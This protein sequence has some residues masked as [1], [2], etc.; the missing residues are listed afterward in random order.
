MTEINT[1]TGW[2]E[3]LKLRL[4]WLTDEQ[5]DELF[6]ILKCEKTKRLMWKKEEVFKYIKENYVQI[7]KGIKFLWYE[8]KRIHIDLPAIWDLK[9][10]KFDY[11]VSDE[12][13]AKHDLKKNQELNNKSCSKYNLAKEWGIWY[14][15]GLSSYIKRYLENFWIEG[16]DPVDDFIT[17][18]IELKDNYRIR[19][20]SVYRVYSFIDK[21]HMLDNISSAKL[22]LKM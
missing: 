5:K 9:W 20:G 21:N 4:E 8:W 6:E 2:N 1:P 19:G 11:F 15:G 14:L 22:L 7:E 18:I 10:F 13:I 17:N 16:Y 3:D 12:N